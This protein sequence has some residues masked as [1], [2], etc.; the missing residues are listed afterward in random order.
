MRPLPGCGYI[1]TAGCGLASAWLRIASKVM[2]T[3]FQGA[4]MCCRPCSDRTGYAGASIPSMAPPDTAALATRC[5]K[6]YMP[7]TWS[8]T[9]PALGY[10]RYHDC[11]DADRP[12]ATPHRHPYR[13]RP[14]GARATALQ[15]P[16]NR[17]E[18]CATTRRCGS[19]RRQCMRRTLTARTAS[20]R[21]AAQ[22]PC[23]V[24]YVY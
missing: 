3:P 7:G 12:S 22:T 10:S 4:A 13:N 24:A 18:H 8:P 9:R 1:I 14:G 2:D 17:D 20:A 21:S 15:A 6:C 5:A 16:R 11:P 19:R 23:S